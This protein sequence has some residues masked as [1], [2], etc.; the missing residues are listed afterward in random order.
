MTVKPRLLDQL[1]DKLRLKHYSIR[2]ERAYVNW[3]R[4]FILF[5]DKRHPEHMGAP[6]VEQFITHLAVERGVAAS[7]QNQAL[8]A[9]LFLYKHVLGQELPWLDNLQWAKKPARLPVVLTP[10]EVRAVLSRLEGRDWL[11]ASLLYG[12]GLRLME[13]VRLRVQD[14]DFGYRQILVRDGKGQKDRVTMLPES[15]SE[16]L[17]LH[18]NRVKALHEEDLREGF[19]EVYLPFALSRK[20]PNAG[21][22]WSWQYVFPAS[23]RSLDPLSSKERRH[24]TDEQNLQ[25]AV[26]GAV[27]RAGIDK[28]ASCHSLRLSFATHLLQSGYDI[29][30]IQELLGHKDVSTTMIYTHVLNQG[31]KGVRSPLDRL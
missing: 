1:R 13:C 3:V 2:T 10:A 26:K 28:P 23:K 21:R 11:M 5:H 31:G 7:T 25:R 16:P 30:T 12:G 15:A 4:Q 24:H 27:R 6:E 8:S 18:L 29:R 20:Y 9:I 14:V 19:G 22:E 17:K